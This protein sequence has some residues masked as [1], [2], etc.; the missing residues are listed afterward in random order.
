[1]DEMIRKLIERRAKDWEQAK[2]LLD[3]RSTDGAFDKA[4][5]AEQYERLNA[6]I[7]E[8]DKR[9][10]DLVALDKAN[11]KSDA[12]REEYESVVRPEV[13]QAKEN[14]EEQAL[15]ELIEGKR[16][17]VDLDFRGVTVNPSDYNK[18]WEMRDLT[19]GTTTA[20]G[21]TVP[22]SFVRSLY[23]HMVETSAIRQTNVTVFTTA[24]GENLE[25][26]KTTSHGTAAIVGEGTGLA[27]AD[28]AFGQVTLGSWKYGQLLQVSNELLQDTGVNILDYL[29]RDMGRA[30]GEASGSD[31]IVG[32]GTNQPN[33]LFTATL[34][35]V[36]TTVQ[37]TDT[38]IEADNV[39]SLFYSV[40]EPYA[41]NGYWLFERAT[42]G[43][44]RKLKDG[45]NQYLWQP[46]LQAG[47]PNLLLGR[48]IVSETHVAS[49]GS[50]NAS[51]GFGDVSAYAIRDAGSIRIERSD[52]Y[53]FNTDLVT[54]RAILRTDGDLIDGTGAFKVMDTD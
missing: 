4:E 38:V 47:S 26:P 30:L 53:A 28:P 43:A 46:G 11:K 1:M 17:F 27:E 32:T 34:A 31:F 3:E 44:I 22:T 39:I 37:G 25:V 24:G 8:M 19:V 29:A 12:Y 40:I 10:D 9:I 6:D 5:D 36:G 23:E 7:R 51:V 16:S 45:N 49:I 42:E 18:P 21:H 20:G 54:W 48:P 35:Q 50:A 41:R 52:D 33:G 15:R 2:A 14:S 13:R